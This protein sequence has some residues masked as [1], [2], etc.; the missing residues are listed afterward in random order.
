MR[1]HCRDVI[2]S[3]AI[4]MMPQVVPLHG[5]HRAKHQDAEDEHDQLRRPTRQPK[6]E[7]IGAVHDTQA[8]EKEVEAV[9]TGNL[10]STVAAPNDADIL[11][12][13]AEV[14]KKI[15]QLSKNQQVLDAKLDHITKRIAAIDSNLIRGVTYLD[16]YFF[17]LFRD[18]CG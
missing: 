11:D 13:I 15:Q 7:V 1:P 2:G 18:S 4:P 12:A 16:R 3:K 14:S 8:G 17:W 9:D 6:C 5:V 10:R